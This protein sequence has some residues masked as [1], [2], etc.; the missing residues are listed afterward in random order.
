MPLNKPS[1]NMFPDCYTYTPV[2]GG[3]C[4]GGCSYCIV[5]QKI[6]P[7][8][9]QLGNEKYIG[10]LRLV[11]D[12]LKTKLVVPD[13]YK[14]FV[15]NL[16]ELWIYPDKIISQILAHC[17]KFPETT[18]LYHTK[19][20]HRY[21]KFMDEFPPKSILGV[22]IETNRLYYVSNA[23]NTSER[24]NTMKEITQFPKTVTIEPIMA[25]DLEIF[26]EWLKEINPVYISIGADSR[27]LKEGD[28][29]VRILEPEGEDVGALVHESE[30]FT[31]VR[32]KENLARIYQEGLHG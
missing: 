13:G 1:G 2:G 27:E 25:F 9:I 19:Y 22:T 11:E 7:W 8:Q 29:Q 16:V 18:F 10:D 28:G 26:I 20:P 24:K 3:P 30:K 17:N 21:L 12:P 15:C 4:P 32:L 14:V 23:P 5:A 6:I 31:E